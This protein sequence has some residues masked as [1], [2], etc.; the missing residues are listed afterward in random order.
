MRWPADHWVTLSKGV[1]DH[2]E[3]VAHWLN[4]AAIGTWSLTGSE[5]AEIKASVRPLSTIT[6]VNLGGEFFGVEGLDRRAVRRAVITFA[7]GEDIAIDVRDWAG[8]GDQADEFIDHVLN[9]IV[10]PQSS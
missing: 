7:S 3:Y 8:V 5:P 4:G 1:G 10:K 2:T 9:A 6:A